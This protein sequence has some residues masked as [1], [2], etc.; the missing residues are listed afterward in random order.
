MARIL[1]VYETFDGHTTR[2]AE[3]MRSRL[4]ESG[5]QVSMRTAAGAS[6]ELDA[7]DAVIVGGSVRY[8]RHARG[9]ERFV[10]ENAGEL[11]KMPGAFF[12]VCLA[13][14]GPK[15]NMTEASGYGEKLL[16]GAGW[17]PQARA[18]FAGALL[19]RQYGLVR[20]LMMRMIAG[21]AGGD[22]DMSRDYEYTDWAA[23]ERFALEFATRI[24][25]PRAA[26]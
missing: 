19:Y 14:A 7:H 21:F 10:H 2:I 15:A 24:P 17:S 5:H 4:L 3:R 12:T 13:A 16:A 6:G 11:A 8:G 9:L 22:T 23:V 26:A 1:I 18:V 25:A 20:R